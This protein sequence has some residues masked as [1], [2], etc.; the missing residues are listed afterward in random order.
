MA[1]HNANRGRYDDA[2]LILENARRL[3]LSTDDP[4]LRI[5]TSI[6]RGNILF[7]LD[8][9]NEA[10]IEWE[11]AAAEGD[12]E[13]YAVLAALARIH[14]IRA[15][16]ML[17]EHEADGKTAAGELKT[18]LEREMAAVSSDP[19]AASIGFIT[20]GLAEKQM[21]RWAE[22]ENAVRRAYV[23]H[24][25]N[26][27]LEEA[28]YDWFLIG[29]IRSL[30]GNY[31]SALEALRTAIRFDRRAENGFG[32]ASSWQAMG[33]VYQKAGRTGESEAAF[34]RAAEIYRAI[35]LNGHAE[36]LEGRL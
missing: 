8:R 2:L 10:F 9:R 28:A 6:S 23:F 27:H 17:L 19:H 32:L 33:E 4:S 34:R 31:D 15:R 22:A 21:E 12:I 36:Q 14:L 30:S 7:S 13:G 18:L 11:N 26:M 1:N 29:S 35:D 25:R 24:E 3:A 5:R 20:L 16:L